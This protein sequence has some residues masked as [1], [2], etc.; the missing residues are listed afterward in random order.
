M[1]PYKNINKIIYNKTF[2]YEPFWKNSLD[3]REVR[4]IDVYRFCLQYIYRVGSLTK[5][6]SL[7]KMLKEA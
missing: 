4:V 1:N 3:M 5:D 2:F 7:A 6:I